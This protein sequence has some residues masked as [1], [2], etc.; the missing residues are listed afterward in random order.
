[1]DKEYTLLEVIKEN[2]N[3][4]QRQI[5]EKTGLS[6]G[7]VNL[8]LKKM[9]KEGLIK[10]ESIP[11]NRVAYML[12][13]KGMAEKIS[14][15]YKYIKHHYSYINETKEKIKAQIT[16]LLE[17]NDKI[18]IILG[19]DDISQLV[20]TSISELAPKG[21]ITIADNNKKL[22]SNIPI[23]VL[24]NNESKKYSSSDNK[25]FILFDML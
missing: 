3:I 9:I 15:T 14:K 4:S 16:K 12:T 22:E 21:K 20:K 1:M 5:A 7:S 13:P 10:V 2:E 19:E 25:V 6:L 17:E 11:A 23:V 24:N 8:L 18:Y